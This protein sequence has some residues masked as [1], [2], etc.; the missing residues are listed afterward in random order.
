MRHL[1]LVPLTCLL[2]A[3]NVRAAATETCRPAS[4]DD[5][6]GLFE[7]WSRAL[8]SGRV[9]AVLANY[10]PRSVLLAPAS[11]DPLLSA[12]Q[13]RA[14]FARLLRRRPVVRIDSRHIDIDCD[15]AIDAGTYSFRFA[16]GSHLT[17]GYSFIYQRVRQRWRIVSHRYS[18]LPGRD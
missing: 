5:I 17:A 3:A 1:M 16:D 9:D 10:A 7:R 15:T 12:R 11:A 18:E 2:L 14:Y 13:K 4:S 6:A 8:A